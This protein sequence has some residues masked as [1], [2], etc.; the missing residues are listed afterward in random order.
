MERYVK[1]EGK[2]KQSRLY[3]LS[4]FF[5]FYYS[6]NFRTRIPFGKTAQQDTIENIEY[7]DD[8]VE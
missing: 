4:C 7:H 5:S 3:I 2:A 1:R 8:E 6:A